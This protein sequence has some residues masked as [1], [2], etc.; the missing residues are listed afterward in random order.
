MVM[1]WGGVSQTMQ[2]VGMG[3][4]EVRV[5]MTMTVKENCVGDDD[6]DFKNADTVVR[7][8][9]SVVAGRRSSVVVRR[10]QFAVR[11]RRLVCRELGSHLVD[12]FNTPGGGPMEPW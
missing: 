2:A 9:S 7:R 1:V 4:V 8:Q 3:T 10:L 5:A 12:S 6:D 11:S